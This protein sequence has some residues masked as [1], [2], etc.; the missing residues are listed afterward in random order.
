MDT[1][2][3]RT[4]K[5]TA[6]GVLLAFLLAVAVGLLAAAVPVE[7]AYAKAG[8]PTD[9]TYSYSSGSSEVKWGIT[10]ARV[11][12]VNN[13]EAYITVDLWTASA[14]T[15]SASGVGW[16]LWMDGWMV[17][18]GTFRS[19]NSGGWLTDGVNKNCTKNTSIKTRNISKMS[20]QR[21]CT[22]ILAIKYKGGTYNEGYAN[23]V[24]LPA[25]TTYN[26][27]NGSLTWSP[28]NPTVGSTITATY[29]L[30]GVP[31]GSL[32]VYWY[33]DGVYVKGGDYATY[34]NRQYTV[35]ASDRGKTIKCEV[36]GDTTA[37]VGSKTK[38]YSIPSGNS[39]IANKSIPNGWY[40]LVDSR[41][42]KAIDQT[43]DGA[44]MADVQL[45]TQNKKLFQLWYVTGSSSANYQFQTTRGY[46]LDIPNG[47]D[48]DNQQLWLAGASGAAPQMWRIGSSVG[49]AGKIQSMDTSHSYIYARNNATANGTPVVVH[50]SSYSNI[51][52]V[53]ANVTA[54]AAIS[55]NG[56]VGGT[57]SSNL[58]KLGEVDLNNSPSD[59][60]AVTYQVLRDGS[61]TDMPWG[62][63]YASNGFA[64]S[65]TPTQADQGHTISFRWAVRGTDGTL[66]DDVVTNGIYISDGKIENASIP[67][68][69]Y[70]IQDQKSGKYLDVANGAGAY[71]GVNVQLW[72]G[73]DT[74]N[75]LWYVTGNA[76][77]GYVMRNA[78]GYTL[79][80]A[81]SVDAD[82]T[83]VRVAN[84]Y[85]NTAQTWNIESSVGSY[86]IIQSKLSGGRY[87]AIQDGA[88]AD[89]TN[90]IIWSGAQARWRLV[91]AD[92]SLV[93]ALAGETL[94]GGDLVGN[95][96]D[97]GWSPLST[98]FANTYFDLKYEFLR[99][100]TTV[101]KSATCP[102][103][104]G[105][106]DSRA[107]YTTNSSDENHYYV[108]RYTAT[109]KFGVKIGEGT[110]NR[111]SIL[112]QGSGSD[113][114]GN[115]L[116]YTPTSRLKEVSGGSATI[117]S[118]FSSQKLAVMSFDGVNGSF[119]LTN[120]STV[121][122]GTAKYDLVVTVNSQT[123]QYDE[124]Q[125]SPPDTRDD[126]VY[127]AFCK[128]TIY[129]SSE[130]Y[131]NSGDANKTTD[132]VAMW[133][134]TW[135]YRTNVTMKLVNAGT[136]TAANFDLWGRISDIDIMPGYTMTEYGS[137]VSPD[138]VGSG[139]YY[140]GSEFVR[141]KSGSSMQVSSNSLLMQDKESDC[142][143]RAGRQACRPFGLVDWW[144]ARI[145]RAFTCCA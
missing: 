85:A 133:M 35:T 117:E 43:N 20:T 37:L 145:T 9:W 42:G 72:Q 68:G 125:P 15:F 119:R 2:I 141:L 71:A 82:G 84:H 36:V 55:G 56:V 134:K 124:V 80:V 69:W 19:S 105:Y 40:W 44:F 28:S 51:K 63:A 57:L 120:L 23:T 83:N 1:T 94:P 129:P 24:Y 64:A 78:S 27:E 17:G 62:K 77:S 41:S 111:I 101:K 5:K 39:L 16:E 130:E 33:R 34:S 121:R 103:S 96:T 53:K 22:V 99:D 108:V 126:S 50:G 12:N 144:P 76:S 29:S 7:K 81:D 127:F 65:Y 59:M 10:N 32:L 116:Y 95:V 18:S 106:Y 31:T 102:T 47:N 109:S 91:K 123:K 45:Y 79:D 54:S 137:N 138:Q 89:G 30:S 48:V 49:T 25:A 131:A 13:L 26:L 70:Y 3:K 8:Q 98:G 92:T 142:A 104:G 21:A 61:Q 136:N 73:S 46:M 6:F 97:G 128:P 100:G 11:T 90:V 60:Y 66:I 87:L 132:L 4:R 115:K 75:Q 107:V 110:S 14:S 74:A 118:P 122:G 140:E 88:T 113:T 67:T 139:A 135:F 38:S 112:P 86:G 114:G 143:G 58:T 93:A 52:L